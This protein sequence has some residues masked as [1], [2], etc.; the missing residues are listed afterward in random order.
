MH[1]TIEEPSYP[2]DA[3][4][5]L[6]AGFTPGARLEAGYIRYVCI[7]PTHVDDD[8]DTI[9]CRTHITRSGPGTIPYLALS[10]A[11][12]D[13]T[14]KH[15]V[16]VD[17]ERRLIAENLWQFLR[18]ARTKPLQFSC[19][20]WID[21]LSIDQSD[22]EERRH[23]VGIMSRIFRDAFEVIVW[24][25][26]GWDDSSLAMRVLS[27]VEPSDS[28]SL[29]SIYSM[30]PTTQ[31]MHRARRSRGKKPSSI[32]DEYLMWTMDVS[33]ALINFCERPFWKRLWVFQELRHAE[34]IRLMCGS[35]I[36]TWATFGNLW[37]VVPELRNL[38]F[39]V[40][41]LAQGDDLDI[42][43]VLGNS[44]ATRMM[45]LR[46]KPMDF[47]LWNLLKETRSLDCADEHDR[48]YALLS[49]ATEGHENIEADYHASLSSLGHSIL[50]NKYALRRP[51]SLEGVMADCN[52]LRDV[53][54]LSWT[55][56][57]SYGDFYGG[58]WAH[59]V[60]SPGSSFAGWAEH[61]CHPA[62]TKLLSDTV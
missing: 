46:M 52:F 1:P 54:K 17:G 10:Y 51:A 33:I 55:E 59:T 53:L 58:V 34:D 56:M 28:Q 60:G 12:G 47:S 25:G 48:V 22:T 4:V 39:A 38:K 40:N 3:T 62:V 45:T 37:S 36:I 42:G 6:P 26:Q 61:H 9:R 2:P 5:S 20:L 18:E 15:P 11:W 21:S 31:S 14:P 30:W 35:R 49:V 50:R 43:Q 7:L 8:P 27:E 32:K 19:W 41:S 57:F 29:R 24:L 13:P 44:L 23:Q 16:L